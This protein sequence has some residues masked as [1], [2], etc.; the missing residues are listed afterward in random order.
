MRRRIVL[1]RE[2]RKFDVSYFL[3][4]M[5]EVKSVFSVVFGRYIGP[6]SIFGFDLGDS[7]RAIYLPLYKL[8]SK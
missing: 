6:Q 4:E 3:D 2:G 8:L 1:P 5:R 7:D